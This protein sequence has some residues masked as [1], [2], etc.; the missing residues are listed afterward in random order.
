M[1]CPYCHRDDLEDV[2]GV[3][4][5]HNVPSRWGSRVL[6]CPGSRATARVDP[7]TSVESSPSHV[8]ASETPETH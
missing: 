7:P 2:D 1:I 5:P 6:T 8:S 4:E 3:I